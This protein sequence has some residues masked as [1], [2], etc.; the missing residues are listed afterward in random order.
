MI[1]VIGLSLL[2]VLRWVLGGRSTKYKQRHPAVSRNQ[3]IELPDPD[4]EPWVLMGD[5]D[6]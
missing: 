2:P 1:V 3:P 5:E 4:N 6:T